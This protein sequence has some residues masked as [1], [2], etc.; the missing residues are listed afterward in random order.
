MM[1]KFNQMLENHVALRDRTP[2]FRVFVAL[3]ILFHILVIAIG[4]PMSGLLHIAAR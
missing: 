4:I 1:T 3:L 2:A